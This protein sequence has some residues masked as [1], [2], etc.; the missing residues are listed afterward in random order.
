MTSFC[1]M[2]EKKTTNSCFH[3]KWHLVRFSN[4]MKLIY[5]KTKW[6][7]N[8]CMKNSKRKHIKNQM[9]R[10]VWIHENPKPLLCNYLLLA[11]TQ[12][13]S[14]EVKNGLNFRKFVWSCQ[15]VWNKVG[16]KWPLQL[17]EIALIVAWHVKHMPKNDWSL[18]K[19]K[20]QKTKS[21]HQTPIS[22]ELI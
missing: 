4:F 15:K 9:N 7:L 8:A 11:I 20:K 14:L 12:S 10:K 17:L 3:T 22:I 6:R 18:T 16:S 13:S 2:T 21:Q 1:P 19:N 5:N